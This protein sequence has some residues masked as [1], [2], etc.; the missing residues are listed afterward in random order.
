MRSDQE[1][2]F[3]TIFKVVQDNGNSVL[4]EVIE[5]E[6]LKRKFD[7]DSLYIAIA[8]LVKRG[9][10]S[11]VFEIRCPRCNEVLDTYCSI[12][13]IPNSLKCYS[14]GRVFDK[15]E[16]LRESLRVYVYNMKFFRETRRT[17]CS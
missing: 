8:E 11:L 3:S 12:N 6:A 2:V 13:E 1:K 14:C 5:R 17:V 10:L 15:K 4:I 7:L 16:D 9:E